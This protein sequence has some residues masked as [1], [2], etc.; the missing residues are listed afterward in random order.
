MRAA[1]PLI[2]VAVAIVMLAGVAVASG[3]VSFADPPRR[4][5]A[6]APPTPSAPPTLTAEQIAAQSQLIA[7]E[8]SMCSCGR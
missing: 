8:P 5:I 7:E 4:A 6:A 1:V 3:A 2:V